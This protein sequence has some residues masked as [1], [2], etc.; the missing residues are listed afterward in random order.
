MV[1]SPDKLLFED[2]LYLWTPERVAQAW[3]AVTEEARRQTPLH[4]AVVLLVGPPGAGKSTWLAAHEDPRFL[5]V[6]AVFPTAEVRQKFL[7]QVGTT[8]TQAIYVR[9]SLEECLRRNATRSSDRRI[10]EDKVRRYYDLL[11]RSPPT[12][13]EGF[14]QVII[15]E[16][17]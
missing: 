13:D 2:G 5:Y 6:D 11:S 15:V 16:T 17:G 9:T 8:S 4:E 10:P 7:A 3:W 1:L 12:L 14:K